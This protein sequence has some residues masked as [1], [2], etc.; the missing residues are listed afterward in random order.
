[1]AQQ[2]V[3]RKLA[4][5]LAADVAAKWLMDNEEVWKPWTVSVLGEGN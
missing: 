1:M 2:H 5:I 3:T 4:A